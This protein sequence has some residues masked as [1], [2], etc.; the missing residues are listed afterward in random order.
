M[1][2]DVRRLFLLA[3][4]AE[5][6]SLT[7]AAEALM[8]TTSAVSQQMRRLEAEAGLV[9]FERHARGVVLTDAGD[10]LVARARAIQRELAGAN[11]DLEALR[12]LRAGSLRIGS[13]PTASSSILPLVLT[14]FG[15][16]HPGI[17]VSVKSALRDALRELLLMREVE[18]ALLWEYDWS[19]F[20][21][22]G[23]ETQKLVDDPTVL[24]VARTSDV[25]RSGPVDLS[26]L[27]SA[28]WIIRADGHPVAD[29]L[30][31]SCHAAGFAP[32]ISYDAHDYQEAQAM[33]A[34]GLGVALAPRLSLTNLRDDVR[35][36]PLDPRIPVP[37]R[38]ILLGH[39][40][41]RKA[42]PAMLG[43][44]KTLEK[45]AGAMPQAFDHPGQLGSVNAS[46]S[47]VS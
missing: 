18:L 3:E 29:V 27:A 21:E 28:R 2:L 40:K 10:A 16:E 12:G 32:D 9:L 24:V 6:G 39:L 37:V 34:A 41:G 25:G 15:R 46:T 38:R 33:V 20:I 11:I 31:R 14:Q 23:I 19:P 45:A 17:A 36:V 47:G 5:H 30:T 35:L 43:F 4:I 26:S 22:E 7:G 13:F 42:T 8:Y 1:N 44:R